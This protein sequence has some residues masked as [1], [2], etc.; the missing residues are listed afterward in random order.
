MA[1]LGYHVDEDLCWGDV[2]FHRV[3]DHCDLDGLV[4][5]GLD[6]HVFYHHHDVGANQNDPDFYQYWDDIYRVHLVADSILDLDHRVVVHWQF[7][8]S[9]K[10]F[11]PNVVYLLFSFLRKA[12]AA[13]NTKA[14]VK[15]Q[16][17][18]IDS[19]EVV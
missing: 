11:Y 2:A 12:I 5:R 10:Y 3:V 13:I 19:F 6:H 4:Y 17:N 15:I 8:Q 1:N 14:N 7:L 16:N 9:Q 18:R